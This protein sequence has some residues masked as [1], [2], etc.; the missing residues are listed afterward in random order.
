MDI[1]HLQGTY[2]LATVDNEQWF[3]AYVKNVFEE[4]I[5][6]NL[7]DISLLADLSINQVLRFL[8]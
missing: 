8:N 3:R 5:I 6:V 7:F 2:C 1:N 4:C